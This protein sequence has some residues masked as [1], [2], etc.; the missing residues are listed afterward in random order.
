M[1][2]NQGAARFFEK[3]APAPKLS[4]WIGGILRA[5]K[6]LV[7]GDWSRARA[8]WVGCRHESR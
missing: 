4:L 2:F 8:A 6:R 7:R 5:G 3:Y 1:Y